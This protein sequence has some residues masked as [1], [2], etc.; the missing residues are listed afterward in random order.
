MDTNVDSEKSKCTYFLTLFYFWHCFIVYFWHCIILPHIF[1]RKSYKKTLPEASKQQ[2]LP[3]KRVINF[4]FL[5]EHPKTNVQRHWF[6]T[7]PGDD[8]EMKSAMEQQKGERRGGIE[9]PRGTSNS[10]QDNEDV[11][12]STSYFYNH[13][14]SL[15]TFWRNARWKS[16]FLDTRGGRLGSTVI[17]YQVRDWWPSMFQTTYF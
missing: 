12:V 17:A 16:Q 6:L 5:Q 2:W 10:T 14:S 4:I 3:Q 7:L 11:W 1:T 8:S 13:I 15:S 9:G